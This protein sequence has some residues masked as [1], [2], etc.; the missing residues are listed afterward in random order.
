MESL[1]FD[2]YVIGTAIETAA[3]KETKLKESYEAIGL[4]QPNDFHEPLAVRVARLSAAAGAQRRTLV[5]NAM[6]ATQQVVQQA[7][8]RPGSA[9]VVK[10]EPL[11]DALAVAE[12]IAS[13]VGEEM[14]ARA[15]VF[16]IEKRV[17]LN[18][19]QRS[20]AAGPLPARTR[21]LIDYPLDG[22]VLFEIELAEGCWHYRDVCAAIADKYDEIYSEAEAYGIWGHGK[23]DLIIEGLLYYP[24]ENVIHPII[25]S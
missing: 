24:A 4:P 23:H 21:L 5:A 7:S 9:P 20:A 19:Y 2:L 1:F 13:E 22:P 25:G 14:F 3:D 11:Q 6:A 18:F 16:E 8:A 10:K 15:P 12:R 17:L